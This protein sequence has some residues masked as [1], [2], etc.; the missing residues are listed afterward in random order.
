MW[1]GLNQIRRFNIYDLI[2][3]A[4]L[5]L[6]GFFLN[7]APSIEVNCQPVEKLAKTDYK[8]S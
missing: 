1:K 7:S 4:V 6:L 8:V 3:N 2:E 5:C